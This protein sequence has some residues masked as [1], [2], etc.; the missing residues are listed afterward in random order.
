[1]PRD[2]ACG[3]HS[4]PALG[5]P[6]PAR[7]DRGAARAKLAI[8]RRGWRPR[9]RDGVRI[10]ALARGPACSALHRSGPS[11]TALGTHIRHSNRRCLNGIV[12]DF[13]AAPREAI[14]FRL[15]PDSIE[16]AIGTQFQAGSCLDSNAPNTSRGTAVL[17]PPRGASKA[18]G[19]SPL[20]T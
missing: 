20:D 5:E 1:T 18:Q 7:L 8:V 9:G 11:P 10:R 2:N 16:H 3:G 13:T 15:R 14:L 17:R 6:R 4:A 12:A 19:G